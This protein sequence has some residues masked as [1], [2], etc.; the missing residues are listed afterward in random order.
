MKRVF[1]F[2]MILQM[3]FQVGLLQTSL[4]RA[5]PQTSLL[6]AGPQTGLLQTGLLQTSMLCGV[7]FAD[8]KVEDIKTEDLVRGGINQSNQ[9]FTSA[10]NIDVK[11]ERLGEAYIP[12]YEKDI[13]TKTGE[14]FSV[15][16]ADLKDKANQRL[17]ESI[18][19]EEPTARAMKRNILPNYEGLTLFK[20]AEE[21][22]A[23]PTEMMKN[24]TADCK[25]VEDRSD[26]PT[27]R[28]Y[29]TKTIEIVEEKASCETPADNILCEKTLKLE[30]EETQ[31][32][33]GHGIV[34]K[35][36]AGDLKWEYVHPH[37]FL[38]TRGDNYW[39][40]TCS[41]FDRKVEF[42]VRNKHLIDEFKLIHASFDDY[43]WIKINDETV[44]V[45]P[46]GG[47]R[48]EMV[49]KTEKVMKCFFHCWEE[50]QTSKG[51]TT[52]GKDLHGSCELN[53]NWQKGLDIDLK[54]HLKEG[55]NNIWIRLVVSGCGEFHMQLRAKQ[56]CCSKVK[57]NWIKTC[58]N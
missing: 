31:E 58:S 26:W 2:L 19:N 53:Q 48:L 34:L 13:D 28:K 35:S 52:D 11:T 17:Q 15:N 5:G 39:C 3:V 50:E 41:V 21:V 57:E 32:C 27:K 55:D 30:C 45:G 25:E 49:S 14:E 9:I 38:G 46:H 4:L 43:L 33:S 1:Y 56:Q 16:D 8:T 54:S 47:D 42:K 40:G 10:E 12:K 20:K 29:K 51:L 44:Y 18:K 7:A 22:Y 36:L 23:N 6:R 37:L 24:L